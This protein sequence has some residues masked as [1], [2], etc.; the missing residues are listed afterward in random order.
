MPILVR[1]PDGHEETLYAT[2]EKPTDGNGLV[3]LGI[4]QPFSMKAME[5]DP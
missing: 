4:T 3:E 5:P 1:H 2:P